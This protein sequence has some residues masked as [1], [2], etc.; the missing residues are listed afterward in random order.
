MASNSHETARRTLAAAVALLFCLGVTGSLATGGAQ[1][2]V[3][4]ENSDCLACHSDKDL[5]KTTAAGAVVPLFV[6]EQQFSAS[7][8]RRNR[9]TSCHADIKGL[10]HPE[11]F[12]AKAV[13]CGQC[14][15]VETGI[16][17]LSD[18]GVAVH[19]GV[20]EAASCK[21]CHGNN[22][23]LLDSRN[24]ASPV[25]RT[26]VTR[27][28]GRCHGNAAEMQKFH[29]RQDDPVAS[30]EASVHGIAF[31]E[32]K[33]LN[34]AVC[35][36]CHGSHDL[37]RSTTPGSKLYWQNVPATCGKC[38][39]NVERTYVHSIHGKAL[40]LGVR[41][42]PVCTDCHG[43]HGI[44]SVKLATSRVS[45]ANIPETCAQCHAARRIIAQYKLAP[46]VFSTY[47]QSFHGLALQG[48]NATVAN[49]SSCHGTHDILPSSDPQSTV[50]A[51]DLPQTCGKCH[52]GIGTRLSAE[53]FTV[54][55]PPGAHEDKPWVVNLV[56]WVYI[57]LIV[58]TVGGMAVFVLL[59]YLRKTRDH[60]RRVK[61][62][63]HA[64]VR[65]TPW[66][67]TQHTILT[68]LFVA[69]AYTGFV[70]KFPEAF[71]SWPFQILP[72]GNAAR[73]LIHRV[74]GWAFAAFFAAHLAALAGT[75]AGR[76]YARALWFV[77]DDI[78]DTIGQIA[79]NL[80]LRQTRPPHRRWNYAEKAE[81]WALVWGSVVMIITGIMLVFTDVVLRLLPKVWHDVAQVVHF[82]EAVLASLA[83]VVWHAYWV[84]F[85][86]AEYPMN[87]SWLIGTRAGHA[88]SSAAPGA[89]VGPQAA[90]GHEPG[91]QDQGGPAQA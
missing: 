18:H 17:L 49:C 40:K 90:A 28:C 21:D 88:A 11:G 80:A 66:L 42:T 71:F 69:L 37:H 24:P 26:N 62:D 76:S 39:E 85:D 65:L 87:P 31:R 8:H 25:N 83:I 55:A 47:I 72:N 51:K 38:H 86:P 53:F 13:S 15:R 36:D 43:E 48:G 44:A 57:V 3:P 79:F 46:D 29:L 45:A 64:E 30:Y 59:D 89:D 7:I 52:P 91:D 73:G 34:A 23:Y 68:I 78:R 27:T 63:V 19:K 33:A 74:A 84:V 54:H 4:V 60:V 75:G 61:A 82:Y 41:D 67:R 50:N 12:A 81:Y 58:V 56:A 77:W 2:T 70:H 10:P 5:T 20:E 9:C 35:T 16:Y 22:H 1:N 14:H 6:D 32:K